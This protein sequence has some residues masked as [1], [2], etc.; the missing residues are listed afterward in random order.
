MKKT[1]TKKLFRLSSFALITA[2][3][4][5]TI[6]LPE[7]TPTAQ[8]M[9]DTNL[10]YFLKNKGQIDQQVSYYGTITGG[11]IYIE[12]DGTLTYKLNNPAT[13][14]YVFKEKII[15][16]KNISPEGK[17]RSKTKFSSFIGDNHVSN[18]PTYST[19]NLGEINNK[20]S[21]KLETR[22]GTLEKI[23]TV[24]PSGNPDNIQIKVEGIKNLE[25]TNTGDLQIS[26]INSSPTYS[27]SKPIAFQT[28]DN[29]KVD[30]T[31]EYIIL[32][33]NSYGF[34]IGTYNPAFPLTIDPILASTYLGGT[35]EELTSEISG[36]NR[37]MVIANNSLYVTGYTNSTDFTTT[38]GPHGPSGGED[39]FITKY[40]LAISTIEASVLIGSTDTEYWSTIT[41]DSSGNIFIA[42]ITR[43][44]AT[45]DYPTTSGAYD[46][47]FNG[48]GGTEDVVVSKFPADLSTLTAS[49]FIGGSLDDAVFSIT[50]NSLGQVYI[51]GETNHAN[52]SDFPVTRGALDN[53]TRT[54]GRDV[55]IARFDNN[56]SNAGITATYFYSDPLDPA[57]TIGPLPNEN[58]YITGRTYNTEALATIGAFQDTYGGSITDNFVASISPDLSTK[59]TFSY[60]GGDNY[61]NSI[62]VITTDGTNIIVLGDIQNAS[63]FYSAMQT[64]TPNAYQ[65]CPGSQISNCISTSLFV[66]KFP[67]DLSTASV[68]IIGGNNFD[69]AGAIATDS[70]NNI[71]ITA[72][73]LST[74][75][76]T[77]VEAY[78]ETDPDNATGNDND[79]AISKF[80]SD[81]STLSSSTYFGAT[82]GE[83]YPYGIYV[84]SSENIYLSGETTSTDL[85]VTINSPQ[86][87]LGGSRDFFVTKFSNDISASAPSAIVDLKTTSNDQSVGLSWSEPANNGSP[88]NS[89]IVEYKLI[90]D[91]TWNTCSDTSCTDSTPGAN[92]PNLINWE[93]YHFRVYTVNDTGTSPVSNTVTAIP[94]P[95]GTLRDND[96]STPGSTIS[97]SCIGAT[98]VPGGLYFDNIPDS[99]SFPQKFYATTAQASFSNDDPATRTIT[100]ITTEANDVL[101]VAD[102]RNDS[103]GFYTTITT[104]EFTDGINTIPLTG[105]HVATSCPDYIA[106][107][108]PENDLADALYSTPPACDNL[109]GVEFANGSII[110][111]SINVGNMVHSDSITGTDKNTIIQA[112]IDD[113]NTLNQGPVNI[114]HSIGSKVA[115]ISQVLNFYLEIPANQP[116]GNYSILFTLDL[117]SELAS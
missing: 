22:N 75:Y 51:A 8:S 81:L 24:N 88:I 36:G 62:G 89:Y 63:S 45:S 44:T 77:T 48:A 20:I 69:N 31:A 107:G 115:L 64:L 25:I 19:I 61:S 4:F 94:T 101:T 91:V 86:A 97:D 1:I 40:D 5:N 70:S 114:I 117:M 11:N 42:A 53:A 26:T 14:S 39:I 108:D 10:S 96:D 21:A 106:P 72:M 111:G 38:T 17:N 79:I 12:K 35:G 109:T 43:P 67:L 27:F 23:F 102:L 100:D 87:T 99:F 104:S 78:M 105:L 82:N 56:L 92:I 60:I 6:P 116:P 83:R 112:F 50:T 32:D 49:T 37:Q 84:D 41:A 68:A 7:F 2:I 85:T 30:I 3:I 28:I 15:T 74:D 33:T 90:E 59:N 46:E 76:P 34:S 47:T 71:F 65:Y 58:V 9:S 80:S 13:D 52:P 57:I 110:S 93:S 98:V 18:I 95:C 54:S 73:T 16:D 103:A 29:K 55:Y 66:A 113:G